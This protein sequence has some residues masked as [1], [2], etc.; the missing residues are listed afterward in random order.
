MRSDETQIQIDTEARATR[1]AGELLSFI[2]RTLPDNGDRG[3]PKLL[4]AVSFAI[5]AFAAHGGRL[6]ARQRQD[7]LIIGITLPKHP[8]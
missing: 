4:L 6:E 2:A 8:G 5:E 3:C 7:V 1:A